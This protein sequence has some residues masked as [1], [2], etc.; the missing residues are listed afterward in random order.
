M[1]TLIRFHQFSN[2]FR[3]PFIFP[4]KGTISCKGIAGRTTITRLRRDETVRLL[5]L[6]LDDEDDGGSESPRLCLSG[7][8][9]SGG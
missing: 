6:E 2:S 4:E 9:D 3:F 8:S 7:L 1:L 5:E